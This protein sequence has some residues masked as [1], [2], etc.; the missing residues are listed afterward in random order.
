[1]STLPVSPALTPTLDPARSTARAS[2]HERMPAATG[3]GSPIAQFR[4]GS[5]GYGAS[6]LT[7]PDCCPLCGEWAWA[8]DDWHP[9]SRR[10]V[11]GASLPL[12]VGGA[13]TAGS[14]LRDPRAGSP[15]ELS[16]VACG[17]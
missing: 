16:T 6:G 4:C 3:L 10:E 17:Q 14:E 9:F 5:C 1:M 15:V 8:H 11:S 12:Q 7:A 13:E 2:E